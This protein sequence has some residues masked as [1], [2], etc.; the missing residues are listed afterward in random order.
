MRDREGV[1]CRLVRVADEK[2]RRRLVKVSFVPDS[3]LGTGNGSL[4][5][6]ALVYSSVFVDSQ[7]YSE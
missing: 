3:I 5:H 6:I 1:G 7:L 2:R 4:A